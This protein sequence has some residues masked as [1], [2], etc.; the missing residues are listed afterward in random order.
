MDSQ[1]VIK[2]IEKTNALIIEY[3]QIFFHFEIREFY[4]SVN[5]NDIRK[6]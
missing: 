5:K 1:I 2:R 3:S 6:I 4:S